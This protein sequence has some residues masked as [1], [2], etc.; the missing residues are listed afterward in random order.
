MTNILI[1][2][3]DISRGHKVFK[4]LLEISDPQDLQ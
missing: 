4:D 3:F 1:V 2:V